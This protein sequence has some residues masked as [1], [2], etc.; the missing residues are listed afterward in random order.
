MFSEKLVYPLWMDGCVCSEQVYFDNRTKQTFVLERRAQH[1]KNIIP[2]FFN[3][4]INILLML[5][6]ML[7]IL[8]HFHFLTQKS[9]GGNIAVIIAKLRPKPSPSWAEIVLISSNCPPTPT[10]PD[11][12]KQEIS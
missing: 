8:S 1:S 12:L 3:S 10:Q 9:P 4:S 6:K 7:I 5:M 11:H 2:S